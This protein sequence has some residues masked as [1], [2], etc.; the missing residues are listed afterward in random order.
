MNRINLLFVGLAILFTFS[1]TNYDDC[2]ELSLGTSRTRSVTP[3][4]FDWE[5][6][7]TMPTPRNQTRIYMPWD[8][9]GSLATTYGDD[10]LYDFKKRDG[11]ILLYNTFSSNSSAPLVNPYFVLYNKYNGLLRFY[12]YVTTSF[13]TTSS[14]IE[15]TISVSNN[16]LKMLNF[17]GDDIV[18]GSGARNTYKQLIPAPFDGGSPLA[19]NKWYMMQYELAYDPQIK[20]LDNVSMSIGMN[21]FDVT[22]FKFEGNAKGS[23]NGT[24]GLQSASQNLSQDLKALG[25]AAGTAILSG[26][27]TSFVNRHTINGGDEGANDLGLNKKVFKLISSGVSGALQSSAGGLP[28]MAIGLISGIIGGSKTTA[29]PVSL[30]IN[31]GEINLEGTGNN[32][33]SLPSMP[34][35]MKIPG[36]HNMSTTSGII[37]LYNQPL[38][39]FNFMALPEIKLIVKTYKRYRYDDPYNPGA[40]ITESWST[41]NIP[42][43]QYNQHIII[44]PAV[45][46]IADVDVSYDLIADEG[47]GNIVVNPDSYSSYDSGEVGTYVEDLPHPN[48]F[49]QFKVTVTPKNGDGDYIIYK[50]FALKN[51]WEERVEWLPDL[52][53]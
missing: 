34:C 45:L 50:S 17:M 23:I 2:Q 48:F 24:I 40:R 53:V 6:A 19:S 37:P 22:S 41:L 44:N 35:T 21:Y 38:G 39:I 7:D 15:G 32:S 16:A 12:Q 43:H 49:V 11:W 18:D 51:I 4:T 25:K 47:D 14:S 3:D 30:S 8:G 29:Q 36:M 13:V 33:G 26:V 27:G 20:N 31:V 46:E 28:G 42:Q 9:P 5:T 1:C 10:V 52:Y